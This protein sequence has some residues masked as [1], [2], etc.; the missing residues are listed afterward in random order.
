MKKAF[1]T[2]KLVIIEIEN[3]CIVST[4]GEEYTNNAPA[5]ANY[6]ALGKERTNPIWDD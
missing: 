1:I 3:E 4:S 5:S 6:Q 2:P